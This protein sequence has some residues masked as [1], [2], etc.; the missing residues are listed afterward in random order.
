MTDISRDLK[1]R[2][3]SWDAD[4]D[5]QRT[6]RDLEIV[7]RVAE[8]DDGRAKVREDVHVCELVVWVVGEDRDSRG[9]G[10]EVRR[11]A[12]SEDML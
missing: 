9:G 1:H 4:A 10:G 2:D 12:A 6:G 11:D 3:E 7:V 5:Q 8:H